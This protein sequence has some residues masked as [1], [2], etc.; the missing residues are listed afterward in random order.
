MSILSRILDSRTLWLSEQSAL[1][2]IIHKAAEGDRDDD[3]QSPMPWDSPLYTV[4]NGVAVIS[5]R[6]V[7]VR[8]CSALEAWYFG[9]CSS[10]RIS[11][12]VKAAESDPSVAGILLDIDSPGG[13]CCGTPE[14]ADV[15]AA[16]RKPVASWS[17]GLMA[18]AAYY[19]GSHARY[20]TAAKSA[21]V[22]SI[23]VICTTYDLSAYYARI[24]IKPEVFTDSPLKGS[25][26]PDKPMT[27]EQRAYLQASVDQIGVSFRAAISARMPAK[28]DAMQ[29]QCFIGA[30]AV[31][32]GLIHEIQTRDGAVAGLRAI[33]PA[34]S[35]T[36]TM[37][38]PESLA[39]AESKLTALEA[40]NLTLKA[41]LSAKTEAGAKAT[42]D[43]VAALA[44]ATE[45]EA[46]AKSDIAAKDAELA[47]AAANLAEV[48][49]A[50]KT[51]DKRAA[52]MLAQVGQ[53]PVVPA[54]EKK[55][56]AGASKP[57]TGL[58]RAIAAARALVAKN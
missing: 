15:V 14:C 31:A 42:A 3:P 11:E 13:E 29:G 34:A 7:I 6:G 35:N 10:S 49:A 26:H 40:E 48:V 22:G 33:K 36:D 1:L 27:D 28:P 21:N 37:T 56:A 45:T 16:C 50:Q 5:I 44:L 52:E 24:G 46:K 55:G 2:P 38:L 19:I 43:A 53:S 58:D 20:V 18:S 25:G 23:G 4:E 51:A 47:T 12:A 54:V 41:E 39:A 30:P 57:L 9:L 17:G 8:E 32:A